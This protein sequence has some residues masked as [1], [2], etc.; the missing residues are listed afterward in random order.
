MHL[1]LLSICCLGYNHANFLQENLDSIVRINYKNIEVIVVDDGSA[2]NSAGIL[3][4]WPKIFHYRLPSFY[5][6]ILGI[7]EK[8]LILPYSMLTENLFLSL[9]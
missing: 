4:N 5:K 7:L 9:L 3:K 2:D 8:T 6:K 1:P